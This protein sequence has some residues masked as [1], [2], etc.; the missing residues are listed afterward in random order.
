MTRFLTYFFVTD[1]VIGRELLSY[2]V[3]VFARLLFCDI[4]IDS[5]VSLTVFENLLL[6][7]FLLK[8]LKY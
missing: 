7:E 2:E 8:V 6:A 1:F 3:S 4:V 5:P